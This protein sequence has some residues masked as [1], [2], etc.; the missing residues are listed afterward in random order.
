MF[1]E[2]Q[3][4]SLGKVTSELAEPFR[5]L[6]ARMKKQESLAEYVYRC[7]TEH[8][9]PLTAKDVQDRARAQGESISDSTVN[10]ILTDASADMRVSTIRALAIGIHRPVEEVVAKAFGYQ[11]GEA[12]LK[13]GLL[14]NLVELYE[15]LSSDEDKKYY[16]RQIDTLIREMQAA[17]QK[18]KRRKS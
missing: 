10:N 5:I 12:E 2:S 8:K 15:G 18:P 1:R 9:P 6:P 3:T 13:K 11:V 17:T 4:I 14:A 16:G 7:M